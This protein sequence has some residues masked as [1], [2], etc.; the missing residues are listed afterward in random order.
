MDWRDAL[1]FEQLQIKTASRSENFSM[2]S[3]IGRVYSVVWCSNVCWVC[4]NFKTKGSKK[5]TLTQVCESDHL[6]LVPPLLLLLFILF[7]SAVS[8]SLL[9]FTTLSSSP[10][11]L[12]DAVVFVLYAILNVIYDTHSSRSFMLLL[13]HSRES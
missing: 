6:F 8:C 2:Q 11:L 7:L 4:D 12:A 13:S 9:R 10:V 3:I 1:I 5:S